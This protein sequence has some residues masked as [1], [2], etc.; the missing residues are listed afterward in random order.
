MASM[1]AELIMECKRQ[2][3][4]CL[5]TSTSLFVWLRYLRAM[6]IFFVVVPLVLGSLAGWNLI[7]NL[8]DAFNRMSRV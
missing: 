6:R 5:Y 3:E 4:N 2:S 7:A 8:T 1:R